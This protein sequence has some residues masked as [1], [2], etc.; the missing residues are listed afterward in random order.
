MLHLITFT[1][2]AQEMGCIVV[3]CF[4]GGALRPREVSFL[5][6]GHTALIKWKK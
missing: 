6:W 1:Q 5:L 4:P 2:Q 3:P